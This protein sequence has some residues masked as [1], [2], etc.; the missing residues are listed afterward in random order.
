MPSFW[1]TRGRLALAG[2]ILLALREVSDAL[3]EAW[4][5]MTTRWESFLSTIFAG[6]GNCYLLRFVPLIGTSP[7]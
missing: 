6:I 2:D 4:A 5:S 7:S 3:E 1:K